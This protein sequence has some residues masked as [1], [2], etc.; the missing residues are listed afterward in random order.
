MQHRAIA[1]GVACLLGLGNVGFYF[2]IHA[3]HPSPLRPT[4]FMTASGLHLPDFFSGLDPDP[5]RFNSTRT[6]NSNSSDASG[7]ASAKSGFL[8]KWL[9]IF[10]PSTVHAQTGC[11]PTSC[12]GTQA[13]NTTLPCSGAG[14]ESQ[15]FES[16]LTDVTSDLGD[17][18]IGS[19]GCPSCVNHPC[20]IRTCAGPPP[21]TTC[22]GANDPACG[23]GHL[24]TNGCCGPLI[25]NGG[26]ACESSQDCEGSTCM[27]DHCCDLNGDCGKGARK[28]P[29]GECLPETQTCPPSPIVLDTSDQGFHLTSLAKGVQFRVLPGGP[30]QQMSW[31]DANWQNGWLVLDRNGNG[32]IDD[33]TELFGD[34]TP[35]PPS[36]TPNGFLR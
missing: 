16:T 27:P 21:C 3:Q 9:S 6:Q 32:T 19:T 2:L 1:V 28:C 17:Y 34:L 24:C 35:Q 22:D 20:Q 5:Q 12:N 23:P 4:Q 7:C 8:I 36:N 30:L 31:T 15:T 25:C 14:C 10:N 11:T 29:N 18:N 13:V 26:F 33:F